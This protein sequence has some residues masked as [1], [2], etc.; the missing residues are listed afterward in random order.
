M[1]LNLDEQEFIE[2]DKK[3]ENIEDVL[4]EEEEESASEYK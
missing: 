4:A 3:Y 1:S 2:K